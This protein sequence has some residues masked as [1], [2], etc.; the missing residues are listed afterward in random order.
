MTKFTEEEWNIIAGGPKLILERQPEGATREA[1]LAEWGVL[2]RN[3]SSL[4][5]AGRDV[6]V[7]LLRHI[8]R[9]Q[10]LRPVKARRLLAER[11]L[12]G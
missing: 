11:L 5:G 7:P 3:P 2:Q 4:L 10:L 12:R 8:G 9:G 1:M 6:A